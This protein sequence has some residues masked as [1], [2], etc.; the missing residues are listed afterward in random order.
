[1]PTASQK[2]NG[3][4]NCEFCSKQFFVVCFKI[5]VLLVHLCF[6]VM[7]LLSRQNFYCNLIFG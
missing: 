1:M 3:K 6:N 5:G 7:F 4:R 2:I